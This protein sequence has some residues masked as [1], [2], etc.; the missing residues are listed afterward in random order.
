MPNMFQK[1]IYNSS[2][3]APLCLSFAFVWWTEKTTCFIPLVCVIEFA[4]LLLLFMA[5]FLYCKKNVPPILTRVCDISPHDGWIVTYLISYI[6]PFASIAL[7]DFNVILSGVIAVTIIVIAPFVNSAIPNP[8]LFLCGYHFYHV[9]TENGV[10][11]Y[12]LITKRK[13]RNNKA[14]KYT[15][16]LFEFLLL[17]EEG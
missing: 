11:E 14:I 8:L 6:L 12:V 3:L 1:C 13:L 7:K 2:S 10:S 4:V 9:S 15:K 16:R 5:S 17:D